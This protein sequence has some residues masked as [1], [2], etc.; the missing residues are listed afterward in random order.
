MRRG[1]TLLELIV[2]IAVIAVLIALLFPA[3]N[4]VRRAASRMSC[5]SNLKQLAIAI[6][7]HRDVNGHFPRGTVAGTELPVEQRLSFYADLLPYIEQDVIHKKLKPTAA[8]DSDANR[9]A[10]ANGGHLRN[11]VCPD[12]MGERGHATGAHAATGH[13]CV[14]NYVGLAG[15]GPDAAARPA[16]AQ[17]IGMFGYDRTLKTAEI[18]DGLANTAMMLETGH[19][20]GPWMRGG[21]GTVRAFDPAAGQLTGDGLPFGGTHFLDATLFESKRADGFNILLADGSIRYTQ[22]AVHPHLLM[23]LATVAGGEEIPAAW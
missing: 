18:K 7:N 2:V 12:W 9:A 15:V 3:H 20:V 4:R 5:Q 1:F 13:L 14:T 22:N 17:G 19:E 23:S 11:L 16:A 8:W 21:P 10:V 6:H